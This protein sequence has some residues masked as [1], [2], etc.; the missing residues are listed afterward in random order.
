MKICSA[1]GGRLENSDVTAAFSAGVGLSCGKN[2]GRVGCGGEGGCCRC[3]GG[4]G[5]CWFVVATG[6]ALSGRFSGRL[7]RGTD[8]F[9]TSGV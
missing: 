2:E 9:G 5:G 7:A 8:P 1:V 6:D 4:A 3:R